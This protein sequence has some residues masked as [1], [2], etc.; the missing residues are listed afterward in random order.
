MIQELSLDSAG[1]QTN[2]FTDA[3][4]IHA[5][6]DFADETAA[7]WLYEKYLP[8]VR[9]V[10]SRSFLRPWMIEDATQDTM[11]RVFQSLGNFE[12]GRC[13]SSWIA[14]IAKHV[15]LDRWRSVSRK[16]EVPLGESQD[17]HQALEAMRV[18]FAKQNHAIAGARELIDTLSPDVRALVE[19]RYMQG[20]SN[21]EIAT[22][23]GLAAGNVA[24]RLMRA[25]Q[26]LSRAK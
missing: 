15:S 14:S 1:T 18:D 2:G 9:H 12:I 21:S 25:R 20:Y 3:T 16:A 7:A 23:T 6:L 26:T 5:W 24:I 22:R 19:M 13:L 17:V 8:L 11:S 4:A 10:C